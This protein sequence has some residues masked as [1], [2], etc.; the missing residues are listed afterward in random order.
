MTPAAEGPLQMSFNYVI[1][2]GSNDNTLKPE[3]NFIDVYVTKLPQQK[4]VERSGNHLIQVWTNFQIELKMK[5]AEGIRWSSLETENEIA[6][7][8]FPTKGRCI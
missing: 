3:A 2:H 1:Q 5:K 4:N 8:P 6:V 7:K